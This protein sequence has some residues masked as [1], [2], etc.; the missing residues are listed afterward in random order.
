MRSSGLLFL[1]QAAIFL[2]EGQVHRSLGQGERKRDAAL[3]S[4][5]HRP[6]VLAVGHIHPFEKTLFEK[7]GRT[8]APV[9]MAFS[10]TVVMEH[11]T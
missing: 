5:A 1:M 7:M 10:Q 9:S 8:Q 4:T 11:R 3:G 6:V 2:A